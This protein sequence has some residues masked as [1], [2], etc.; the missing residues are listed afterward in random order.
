MNPDWLQWLVELPP[1]ADIL[2]K[3]T[4][5]LAIGWMGHFTL[6]R[7]NPRWRALLWRGV[8]VGLV[9]VPLLTVSLP[10]WRVPV[11]PA[12]EARPPVVAAVEDFTPAANAAAPVAAPAPMRG[13][14]PAS[15]P[16]PI[17]TT[18]PEPAP[19]ES[20]PH[21]SFVAWASEHA[22]A[23]GV[24][25]WLAVAIA[26]AA[27]FLV[28]WRR[29]RRMVASAAAVP[30]A[31]QAA[32]D[33]TSRD[34]GAP[35]RVAVRI[36]GQLSSPF[37]TGLR[38]PV[39]ILPARMA[40][41][42]Y[43][44]E[45]RSILAHELSHLRS[46]DLLWGYV[47]QWLSVI[48]WFHPLVW[49][50]RTVHASACEEVSDAITAHFLGDA[51][52]YSRTLAR[53][54]LDIVSCPPAFG[55]IPMARVSEISRRLMALRR[56]VFSKP[57]SRSCVAA[58]VLGGLLAVAVLSSLRAASMK[59]NDENSS[60]RTADAEAKES[61]VSPLV[62]APQD[63]EVD[64]AAQ[65]RGRIRG[66]IVNADT[67]EPVAGAEVAIGH[68]LSEN[69][70]KQIRDRDVEGGLQLIAETD[71]EGRFVME[72]VAFWDYHLFSVK[73]SGFVSHE[74]WVALAKDK[75]EVEV[76]VNLKPAATIKVKV[77]NAEGMPM[78]GQVVR[79]ESKDGHALLPARG[80]WR[81]ELSYRTETAKMGLCS[82]EELPPG[83][84]SVEAMLPGASEMTHHGAILTV[85]LR[86]GETKE[87]ELKA[88]KTGS[89]VKVKIEEDPH[90]LPRWN[91]IV[92]VSR[93][94]G[95]LAWAGRNCYHP[96]DDRLGRVIQY[97]V[98]R[99]TADSPG[100]FRGA[101]VTSDSPYT[102]RNFPPGNYAIL[103]ISWGNYEWN[104]EKYQ[105]AVCIR[106]ARVD[107]SAGKEE[108]I[109]MPWVEPQGP[110]PLNPRLLSNKVKLEAREYG[111]QEL[112]DLI[113][114]TAKGE[115]VSGSEPQIIADSS[116]QDKK[117]E[118]PNLEM[119]LWNLVETIYLEKGWKLAGDFKNK[120][121]VL[122][123]TAS[124]PVKKEEPRT[125]G[126]IRGVVVNAATGEPIAGAYVAVD[127]SGDAG[128]TNLGRFR[129]QGI[130]ATTDTD[131][132]GR[133][134]LDG[135]AF[136]DD[137]PF[138]ATHPG[139]VRHQQ[140]LALYQSKPDID[141]RV[142]LRP[143]ATIVARV[144]DAEG[145]LLKDKAILR[146]E[147]EDGRPF[148]PMRADWPDLPYRM[149][150]TN[151]GTFSFG[152]L[153]TGVYSI[154]VMRLGNMETT[155][156]AKVPNLVVKA[157]ETKEALLKP[158]DHRSAVKITIEKDPHAALGETKGAAA[159]LISP[160]PAL[161]AW[162]NRNF[163]HPEDERLGRVWK[164]AIIMAMMLPI[165]DAETLRKLEDKAR[166]KPPSKESHV[167]F[168]LSS[169]DMTYTLRNF[170]PGEYAAFTYG[171]GMYKDWKSPAVYMR[172]VKAVSSPGKELTV[173][174]PYV[175]P[176][177]PS[178]TNT[179]VFRN[180]VT[181]K[182][183]EYTAREICELLIK[184][185]GAKPGDLVPDSS[186][187][188]EKVALPAAEL[189]IWNLLETI[190][191]KRGWKLEADYQQRKV[192]L[193]PSVS[194]NR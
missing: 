118:F 33:E 40:Q 130:Y 82:F 165:A 173:A 42:D 159:L 47:L 109:E 89:L 93:H 131:E 123:P 190:Y 110:S 152:E 75:P 5:L 30:S 104:N 73:L 101:F 184:E 52:A 32:C 25:A 191:L 157:G 81:P 7:A 150:S 22:A 12:R 100:D 124:G 154:E 119:S 108:T 174:I 135:V 57:L 58:C 41:P 169:Q 181:L 163:H 177:G 188:G 95:V 78:L 105:N 122:R 192:F 178:P 143:A 121:L 60:T 132:D 11:A 38:R 176:I 166:R 97:M 126:Q 72:G 13:S 164:S 85:S 51:R 153:D 170:P 140:A 155:Y 48:F 71:E 147:A 21:F 107:F 43:S 24:G 133:F 138:M 128:G 16:F 116:I 146:L 168:F 59:A 35:R 80:D 141:V 102:F 175:E 39:L 84:Y 67:G 136:R 10:K 96:E 69:D 77:L 139:F 182:A 162:A 9:V 94:P 187:E 158:A 167:N 194:S 180:Q 8:A 88:L 26:F 62:P 50:M 92:V 65:D 15:P 113:S 183:R 74:E 125:R 53:V 111:A 171:M 99:R 31:L 70:V 86:G 145:K 106:G 98:N 91:A 148:F 45:L 112:C 2:V 149:E 37:L 20:R 161:L 117:V 189:E 103:V 114:A 151:D 4:V 6:R 14:P 120:R 160:N 61:P 64:S 63:N 55:G 18:S 127:H 156:H 28:G 44:T 83:I 186:I 56:R 34:L 49:R 193:R 17:A 54:A 172:G 1:M 19:V 115:N 29:V 90:M 144:V 46:N 185:T 76:R 36:S 23:L 137:H 134:V 68:H 129:E 3:V 87:V 66:V 179:R 142:S 27:R 79:I